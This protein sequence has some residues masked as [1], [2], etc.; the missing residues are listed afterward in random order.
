MALRKRTNILTCFCCFSILAPDY[1]FLGLKIKTHHPCGLAEADYRSGGPFRS[2]LITCRELS[3]ARD[4][5]PGRDGVWGNLTFR[6]A[7]IES[8]W[9]QHKH[10]LFS[11]LFGEDEPILTS[12]FFKWVGWNHQLGIC[13]KGLRKFPNLKLSEKCPPPLTRQWQKGQVIT[14]IF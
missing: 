7:K 2:L 6:R 9:W 4:A 13:L 8:R 5:G 10:F 11:S 1:G 3:D 14:P 12:I